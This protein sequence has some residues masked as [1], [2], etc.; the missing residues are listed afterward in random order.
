[1]ITINV[2]ELL[3]GAGLVWSGMLIGYVWR[4]CHE[5]FHRGDLGNDCRQIHPRG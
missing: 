5:R 1:M 2:V 4:F 3:W